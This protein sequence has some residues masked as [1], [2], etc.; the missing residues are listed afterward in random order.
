MSFAEFQIR[1][2]AWKR[3]QDREWEKTRLLAWHVQSIS[4]NRK[5]KMPSIQKFMPLS[6]D[7]GEGLGLS[8]AQIQ[9]FKEVSAEYYKQL[10]N[11]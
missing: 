4:M 3:C 8:E 2:F 7:K 10:N 5:G 11:K 9:R 6:I 1:L